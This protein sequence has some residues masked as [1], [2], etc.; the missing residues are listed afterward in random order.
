MSSDHERKY[1]AKL[2]RVCEY[3]DHHNS[4]KG[5][6]QIVYIFLKSGMRDYWNKFKVNSILDQLIF[7]FLQFSRNRHLSISLKENL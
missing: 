6:S 3:G 5:K 2:F 7:Y 1:F 4:K